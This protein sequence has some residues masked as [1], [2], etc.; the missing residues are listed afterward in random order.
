MTVSG[1]GFLADEAIDITLTYG[2]PAGLRAN[3]ALRLAAA[4]AAVETT[5]A[6]SSGNFST[7]VV[8]TQVGTAIITATGES[9]GRTGSATVTVAPEGS[10]TSDGT[11]VVETTTVAGAGALETSTV[12]G[13][14]DGGLAFTGTSIAG[15]LT[16]GAV[17]VI[18]GLVLL[19]FG[20]RL[21]ARRRHGPSAH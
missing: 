2:T 13:A 5:T 9:S 3:K 4:A 20:T 15:P 6:D 18:A 12:A 21:A 14:A 1:S 7:N 17:A 10:I 8:L 16:V 11:T 19:F